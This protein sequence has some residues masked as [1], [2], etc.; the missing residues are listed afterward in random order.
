MGLFDKE[1]IVWRWT[2]GNL[3]T[4]E[5][6]KFF[7]GTDNWARTTWHLAA[8]WGSLEAVQNYGC[9]LKRM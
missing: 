4:A 9:G 8:D 5:I 2:K 6:N 1:K 7:F 3:T